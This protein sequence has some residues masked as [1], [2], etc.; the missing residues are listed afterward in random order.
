MEELVEHCVDE[1]HYYMENTSAPDSPHCQAL[2]VFAT[3]LAVYC[4]E[5]MEY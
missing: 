3:G 5:C 4:M 1:E 2:I